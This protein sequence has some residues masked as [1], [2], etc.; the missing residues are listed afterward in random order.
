MYL[1]I[2]PPIILILGANSE[3]REIALQHHIP[4][5]NKILY[6]K[7]VNIDYATDVF[8]FAGVYEA[9][10]GLLYCQ[11]KMPNPVDARSESLHFRKNVRHLVL[12]NTGSLNWTVY[13]FIGRMEN[14]ETLVILKT[15]CY[16][17]GPVDDEAIA[18]FQI[19]LKGNNV[20][21]MIAFS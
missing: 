21:P 7:T 4:Q 8:H 12:D 14:L 6:G 16:T 15:T 9:M 2:I 17:E 5:F 10:A 19:V 3:A 11:G 1:T 13:Q 18:R 20:M